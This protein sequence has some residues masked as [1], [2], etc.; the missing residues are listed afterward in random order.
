MSE[1]GSGFVNGVVYTKPQNEPKVFKP[2][3]KLDPIHV[4]TLRELSLTELTREQDDFNENGLWYVRL[5]S[6][7]LNVFDH[8]LED[9]YI[10]HL[11]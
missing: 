1:Q 7:V 6:L 8:R 9:G 11:E 2:F 5:S 10:T 4:N 3:L